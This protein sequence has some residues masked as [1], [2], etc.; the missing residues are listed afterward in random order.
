MPPKQTRTTRVG[1]GRAL[2]VTT[3]TGAYAPKA[4]INMGVRR[5]PFVETKKREHTIIAERNKSSGAGDAYSLQ[6]MDFQA[7]SNTDAYF[8]IHLNSFLRTSQGLRDEQI[9]GDTLFSRYLKCKVNIR[10]PQG[11]DTMVLPNRLYMV[12]GWVTAPI[13]AN[14]NRAVYGGTGTDVGSVNATDV[15]LHI[16]QAVEQ[17]FN[18]PEDK[19]RFMPKETTDIK[20]LKKIKLVPKLDEQSAMPPTQVATTSPGG[21]RTTLRMGS[22]P[23][24]KR[25]FTWTINRKLHLDQGKAAT[26]SPAI[27]DGAADNSVQTDLQNMYPNNTWLPFLCFYNPDFANYAVGSATLGNNP[28]QFQYNDCHWYSDS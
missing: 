12:Q 21:T 14:A 16:N 28:I 20:I 23:D 26:V 9:V 25:S 18:Q 17:Y 15:Q 6:P 13:N 27:G 4:K 5:R 7:I 2:K 3:E 19:L 11:K 10:F 22:I 24:I 8:P 1:R